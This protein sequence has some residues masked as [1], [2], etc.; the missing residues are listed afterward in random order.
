MMEIRIAS[1]DLRSLRST[2]LGLGRE[3][4]AV[5]L[6]ARA[7]LEA[8]RS[9]L[10]V[11][12]MVYPSDADYVTSEVDEAQLSPEF[13]ARVTKRARIAHMALVF[14]HTHPGSSPPRFSSVD[15]LG[16]SELR[17]FL[18]RRGL[19]EAHAAMVMSEGGLAA[20]LLGLLTPARVVSL[21]EKRVIEFEGIV[22]TDNLQAEVFDRQI[23]AFGEHGQ[24]VL[25]DLRVAI[26][27]LGGTGS[28]AMQQ[29][30]HLGVKNFILIDPDTL[31][32]SNL[33]R[34]V[35]TSAPDVGDS[36]VDV[37]KR[38]L[39]RFSTDI[40]VRALVGDVVYAS[41][42]RQLVDAD[43]I[44]ACTDSH[45]SRAVVQQ[46]AYQYMI[47]CIDMG[48]TITTKS[49]LVTGIFGRVQLL[50]PGHACLWCSNLLDSE[51]VRRDMMSAYERKA[52][53]Y[54]QGAHEPAPS[55]ISL[56]GTVVSLAITMLLGVFTD[57]PV[58]ACHLI[59]NAKKS[60]LRAVHAD[61]KDDCFI[62]SRAGSF[63]QGD[64]QPLFARQ[65]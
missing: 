10:L 32:S 44:L 26:V 41:I 46:V 59:Y 28:I 52:D 17:K 57:I 61:A 18:D 11:R 2:L 16:E 5:L 20:R 40:A 56:N 54:V 1:S 64:L 27:G 21:G 3:R 53:P 29:L 34:V 19:H 33:N 45:G 39:G 47:P 51:Q 24:R 13:V 8:G 38:F 63:A 15:D 12:E 48:S 30:A 36:K 25:R 43:L 37:A 22:S 49:G 35:G 31:E 62:C 7:C 14:V 42:A 6:A 4:C 60:S 50:G 55:V 23:R 58:E 9:L 65:D